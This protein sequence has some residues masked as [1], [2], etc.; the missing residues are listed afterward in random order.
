MRRVPVNTRT[1]CD[2]ARVLKLTDA[3][4]C[5]RVEEI[6]NLKQKKTKRDMQIYD[7]GE[8]DLLKQLPRLSVHEVNVVTK[9]NCAKSGID[10]FSSFQSSD[11]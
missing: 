11:P 7:I 5:S 9:V 4:G 8:T 6:K 2:Q 3:S 10:R 1:K